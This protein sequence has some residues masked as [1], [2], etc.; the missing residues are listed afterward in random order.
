MSCPE[1]TTERKLL[2]RI[3]LH[4]I[5]FLC[6]LYLLAFLDRVNIGN[7][8]VY[9]LSE[10]L[11]LKGHEYNVA[12]VVFFI[13]Y[14]LFEIPSNILLKHFRPRLWLSINMFL[15]GFAT[16]M[17]GFV[18]SYGSL[19]A[20]RFFLGLF[21]TGMFPGCFY[22]IG[23]W[24]KRSEAQKRFTFFFGSTTLAGAFG[25][26][27]AAGIG[28]MAG[29]AGYSGWRW[30]FILEGL[31]TV[32]VACVF[33]FILPGFPEEAKWLAASEKKYVASR[34]EED[35]GQAALDKKITIKDVLG[36]FKDFK[37]Y[38]AALMYMGVIVSS[39]G[40]AYFS[41]TLIRTYGYDPIHTQLFSVPPWASAFIFSMM[42]AALSDRARM[43]MPFAISCTVMALT[44]LAILLKVH[45]DIHLQYG[46][47]FLVICGSFSA[48]P[49]VVC[50][51]TMNLG[52]HHR[53]S[54]GT[55][56]II[57]VGNIGGIVAVFSFL[58]TDAP[59]YITGYSICLAFATLSII[60]AMAYGFL[61]LRENQKR[62]QGNAAE[63]ANVELGDLYDTYRYFL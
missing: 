2:A 51:F 30:I 49:L 4:V 39:Y 6:V 40:Y 59:R 23:M 57:S 37:I 60:S 61:C 16:M 11:G 47:L 8:N 26:L 33:F 9:G 63:V 32:L 34:L 45:D 13:P 56:W 50:W 12:L 35:Q 5:P 29:T 1:H 7:A 44:G 31:F 18:K 43:R 22:L 42:I 24:Y 48:M 53:R 38:P 28:K 62:R 19:V 55:A 21:E 58:K 17:Q 27:I 10:E 14:I 36:L 54:V 3:D 15:F 52:G 20:V 46:A 25:G 41:P